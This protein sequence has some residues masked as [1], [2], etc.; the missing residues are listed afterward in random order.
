MK[1]ILIFIDW[2]VPAYKAGGPIR[3]VYN[4]VE[5]LSNVYD[6]YIIT[7]SMD[8]DGSVLENVKLNQWTKQGKA[9]V[10]YLSKEEI[11]ANRFKKEYQ[12]L[13]PDQIYLNSLFSTKFTLLPLFLFRK[14]AKVVVA[15]RGMLG[16][17]SLAIK[18]TKKKVFLKLSKVLGLYDA[19]RWHA[20]SHQELKEIETVF[21]T[22]IEARIA[23]NL[24]LIPTVFTP[25]EKKEGELSILM[26][27]RIVP[28]KNIHF[29]LKVLNEVSTNYKLTIS[30][31]GPIEDKEYWKECKQ[32]IDKLPNN[33]KVHN[34]GAVPP[35][36]VSKMF[37]SY[38]VL[39]STSLNENYGH[40]IAEALSFGRPAIVSN[41]TPWKKLTE[42][43]IGDNLDLEI[44]QF[45]TSI[46]R[47][48]SLSN[49][50]F[51]DIQRR[52][53]LYAEKELV[54]DKERAL[55]INVFG[56]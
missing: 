21:G 38:Q 8:R 35:I 42:L 54:S 34:T 47:F 31:V 20:T 16:K 13:N 39:V 25:L 43:K 5:T 12:I 22:K 56:E 1:K 27:G 29:F 6:F 2:Y 11:S 40:S 44:A 17:A 53:R 28:I 41:N 45:R 52:V 51:I 9:S 4:L 18:S 49:E 36:E 32:I 14:K 3:S 33:I 37:L 50:E 24:A 10:L 55:A 7:S 30:L 23:K 15:P 19:V 46:E 48:A 26:I